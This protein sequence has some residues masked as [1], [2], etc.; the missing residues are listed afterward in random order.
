MAP[1]TG[2]R[3][4]S[5]FCV[6]CSSSRSL[7][8]PLEAGLAHSR[9]ITPP[10]SSTPTLLYLLASQPCG[11]TAGL[12]AAGPHLTC[13]LLTFLTPQK[14]TF[15]NSTLNTSGLV[16]EGEALPIPGAHRPGLVT[17]AG[18]ILFGNDDKMVRGLHTAVSH[19]PA[20]RPQ[21]SLKKT[22]RT[23]SQGKSRNLSTGWL[24]GGGGG[25]VLSV[26]GWTPCVRGILSSSLGLGLHIC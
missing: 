14:L 23:K 6:D 25:T 18:L 5:A 7:L 16:A 21:A 15:F 26:T 12:Q 8:L 3:S 1:K 24:C 19:L 13:C 17:K 22:G 9:V 11:A 2:S 10:S 20:S 4:H